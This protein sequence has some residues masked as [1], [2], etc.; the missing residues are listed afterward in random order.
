MNT[1]GLDCVENMK[2]NKKVYLRI[3]VSMTTRVL[4]FLIR[5]L[6]ERIRS[7]ENGGR[8]VLD[9]IYIEYVCCAA[10]FY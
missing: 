5:L 6:Q 9:P 3:T 10:S 8:T 7:Y 2:I 4:G 1:N